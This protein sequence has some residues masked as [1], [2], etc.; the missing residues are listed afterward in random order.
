LRGIGLFV[1]FEPRKMNE[2]ELNQH[3]KAI[4]EQPIPDLPSNFAGSVLAKIRGVSTASQENWLD[5]L[6]TTL[7][8][9][10]WATA[11]LII[12]LLLGGNLGR[13]LASS[14]NRPINLPLGFEVF[15][16]DAP[17]LPSTQLGQA[18]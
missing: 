11:V 12:A 17:T 3:L 1:S 10:Q 16:A 18:R 14:E 2:S 9:P 5:T 15:A 6:V 13:V 4:A 8:R 7:L